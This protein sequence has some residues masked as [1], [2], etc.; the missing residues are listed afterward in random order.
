MS[1]QL[2]YTNDASN[3]KI[4]QP[5]MMMMMILQICSYD[6]SGAYRCFRACDLGGKEY[7]PDS[8]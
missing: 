3:H 4:I 1:P 8:L 2:D 6:I 5:R 7:I